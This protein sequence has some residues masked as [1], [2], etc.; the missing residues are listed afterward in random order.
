MIESYAFMNKK[1]L[2][3][4]GTPSQDDD[5]TETL[6]DPVENLNNMEGRRLIKSHLSRNFLPPGL[7]DRSKVIYVAR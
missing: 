7:L 6:A 4:V 1:V 2:D 5:L 3:S